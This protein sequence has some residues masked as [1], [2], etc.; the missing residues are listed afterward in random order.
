MTM[1]ALPT[2]PATANRH[3]R[4]CCATRRKIIGRRT[5][6]A[7][8]APRA[9]PRARRARS[10]EGRIGSM[11]ACMNDMAT[12][13]RCLMQIAELSRA[14]QGE[15]YHSQPRQAACRKRVHEDFDI[16]ANWFEPAHITSHPTSRTRPLFVPVRRSETHEI[17]RGRLVPNRRGSCQTSLK[18]RLR[19]A[20]RCYM[21][22]Y[23]V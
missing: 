9:S 1:A 13:F 17:S 20:G 12:G 10:S 22:I 21:R 2:T 15:V 16:V 18:R 11:T 5:E 7:R 3:V 4:G 8:P 19:G 14:S 23:R 6:R